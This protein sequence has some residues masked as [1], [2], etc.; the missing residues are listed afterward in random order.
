M[1]SQLSDNLEPIFERFEKAWNGPA[2]PRIEDYLPAVEHPARLAVLAE[3]VRIDLE[4][5]LAAGESVR[6]EEI[7]LSRF[8]E[9]GNHAGLVVSLVSREFHFRRSREPRLT[10]AEYLERWPQYHCELRLLLTSGEQPT[11]T[12]VAQTL[13]EPPK[14]GPGE[15]RRI[16]GR[17]LDCY[18]LLG[19]V[20]HG[21]GGIV[22]R[23]LHLRLNRTVALKIVQESQCSQ[24]ENL[25]RFLQ[26]AEVV[27]G[28]RHPY[29]AQIYEVGQ[30]DSRPYYTM[31][32]MEG[33]SLAQKCARAPQPPRQA[34]Q[35]VEM[36][37]RAVQTAHQCGIIHRDLKPSNVLL[38]SDGTPRITDFGLAKR[39]QGD[40]GLTQTGAVMGTP[41]YMPPEQAEGKKE[42]GPAADIYAL[43]AILYEMLTGRPPFVGVT[44]LDILNQVKNHE[45][46]PF[47]RL[48][49]R[50]PRDLETICLKCLQK[51]P[52]Q[53]YAC[54]VDLAEDLRRFLDGRPIVARPIGW[55]ASLWLWSRRAERITGAGIFSVSLGITGILWSVLGI[56]VLASGWYPIARPY[57]AILYLGVFIGLAYVPFIL[58][59]IG[60]IARKLFS[61]WSG[62]G[63]CLFGFTFSL[64]M[65]FQDTLGFVFEFGGVQSNP[66][67]RFMT[68]SLIGII[69]LV[70]LLLHIVALSAYYANRDLMRGS[71]VDAG[72]LPKL[73]GEGKAG[74]PSP[75]DRA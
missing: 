10:L 35:M 67:V 11:R 26:E 46:L 65:I 36:L 63:I 50:V 62:S 41:S 28:L 66:E 52:Q 56:T 27:A 64:S 31:E 39:V 14:G 13:A 59:G 60:V 4:R 2:P 18:E 9:L 44:V 19:E 45:P 68:Y 5:R 12:D 16:T 37:A 8:P 24:P 30:L 53:R 38:A 48:R 40:S 69:S 75:A 20:G 32:F 54:A 6:V 58:T 71:P 72:S 29:I 47:T 22:Y 33:G 74:K 23:A 61:L 70:G 34:A 57:E 7:Y 21:A 55:L 49:I 17:R 15:A 51:D 1:S 42:V 3:L 73:R 43:G 25:V